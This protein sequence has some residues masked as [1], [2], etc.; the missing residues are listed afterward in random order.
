MGCYRRPMRGFVLCLRAV[1]RRR[2][3]LRPGRAAEPAGG[4]RPGAAGSAAAAL[5]AAS[6]ERASGGVAGRA[7][8][9]HGRPRAS[10]GFAAPGSGLGP[11]PRRRRRAAARGRCGP[12]SGAPR[13]LPVVRPSAARSVSPGKG[14]KPLRRLF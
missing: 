2:G 6:R 4:G 11:S 9:P 7:A 8:A 5:F 3:A 13:R 12:A 10:G 14:G 1:P